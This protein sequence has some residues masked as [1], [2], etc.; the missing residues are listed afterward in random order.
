MSKFD[1]IGEILRGIT[2]QSQLTFKPYII[3]RAGCKEPDQSDVTVNSATCR[4]HVHLVYDG[5]LEEDIY[6]EWAG[7]HSQWHRRSKVI[8]SQTLEL[9]ELGIR[10][11]NLTF[12][13]TWKDDYFYHLE[14][15]RIY[16]VMTIPV[17]VK[18][19]PEMAKSSEFDIMAG[20]RWADPGVVTDR[21]GASPYQPFP[22]VLLSNYRTDVGLV[23]GTLSQRLFYHN[24]L[25]E[26]RQNRICWDMLSSFKDIGWLECEPGRVLD[27]RWYLG[28]TREADD[29]ERVFAEYVKVLKQHLP[30]MYGATGINRHS[31]I[32][33]SWN[34]GICR[35][36]DQDRLF[37]MADFLRENLPTVEWVQI[38]GGY[39]MAQDKKHGLDG[40]DGLGMPY[41]GEEGLDRSKFPDGFKAFTDGIKARGLRPA[42]WIGGAVQSKGRLVR[43]HPEWLIDYSYRFDTSRVLDVSK[44]E[45]REYMKSALDYY[46]K[47][48]GFEGMKHD[49]WSYAYEDSH[50]LLGRRDHSGYEWRD[51]WLDEIRK[52]LPSDGYLQTACD[53]VMANPFLG[54]KFTNY[55][56]GI[57]IGVGEWG[58]VVTNFLW[59]AACFSTHIGDLFVPNSDSIGLFPGLSNVEALT[60]IN[61]CLISRSLVE[62]SGWLYQQPD[63]PRMKWVRKALCCPNNGQDVYFV[64]YDYRDRSS[65]GPP[66]WYL[67]TPHFTLLEGS[68][69]MPLRTVAVFN[70]AD[71]EK[72]F[73]L[74]AAKLGLPAGKYTITDI[75]SLETRDI[76]AFRKFALP[77]RSSQLFAVNAQSR[78]PKVLDA[79]IKITGAELIRNGLSV[80]FAHRGSL[81]LA[82]SVRPKS[83][84]F[85]G[86]ALKAEIR[87]GSGN[88]TVE[89]RLPEPGTMAI[90]F[91]D[92]KPV[93]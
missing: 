68:A 74:T 62:V 13:R 82:L 35:D 81:T 23:H 29:V 90:Q 58:N 79:D 53:I 69:W 57:D 76:K 51:W 54:E 66:I 19:T 87:Q 24:Y 86:A 14:N 56:Y 8:S 89:C 28:V 46:F 4:A 93:R 10:L 25:F 31:V 27:D 36:I 71:D 39:G 83:V 75:W 5:L 85:N 44:P 7:E 20:T 45:V 34:D 67:R 17:R 43:E 48:G 61:Y 32:W 59:G 63:H 65:L 40:V 12:S 18:R 30:V 91:A 33:G 92:R 64:D 6:V 88:W 47:A 11:E 37:K 52:R 50:P 80:K 41:E 22:A 70:L 3:T 60:C 73:G 15:P 49:F 84:R 78:E 77:G 38:D 55:R 42:T 2:K 16:G 72:S 1:T 21:V 26:H 9:V